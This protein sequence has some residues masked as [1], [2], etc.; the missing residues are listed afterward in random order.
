M[1]N[2]RGEAREHVDPLN[3]VKRDAEKPRFI[4]PGIIRDKMQSSSLAV[5][6]GPLEATIWEC[7]CQPVVMDALEL[8]GEGNGER[9]CLDQIVEKMQVWA[10]EGQPP[11]NQAPL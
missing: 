10:G 9:D 2:W 5:A 7:F 11:A 4:C 1:W 3:P 8:I 6:Q